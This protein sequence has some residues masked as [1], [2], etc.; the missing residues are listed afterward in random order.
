MR[1]LALGY[2]ALLAL[3]ASAGAANAVPVL[4]FEIDVA[5][6][7]VTLSNA[8]NGVICTLTSC[9]IEATLASGFGGTFALGTGDTESFDFI[10]WTGTGTGGTNF[11]VTASLVFTAPADAGATGT[12][13]GSALLLQGNIIGGI[14]QWA[15][16]PV[17]M[18]LAQGSTITIDFQDGVALFLGNSVTTSATV[19]GDNIVAGV[20]E[21]P[22]PPALALF[23]GGLIGT[24][25]LARRRKPKQ[26]L[27]L[28]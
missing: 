19:H 18:L 3:A 20:S 16:L 2:A 15:N 23:G 7:S 14:L 21:V 11:D 8:G 24:G 10:T 28:A 6:S 4:P 17:Q 25:L 27:P 22:I 5:A 12:G 26:D 9:G 1:K 13:T